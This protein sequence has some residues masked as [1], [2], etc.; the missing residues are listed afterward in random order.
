MNIK[1]S[2][3]EVSSSEKVL[4]I[5]HSRNIQTNYKI[6]QKGTCP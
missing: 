5:L 6:K 2:S 3:I 4:E 1:V